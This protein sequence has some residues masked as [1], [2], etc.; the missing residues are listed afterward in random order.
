MARRG[1]QVDGLDEL[2]AQLDTLARA[3]EPIARASLYEGARVVADALAAAARGLPN[4]A[5]LY[6]E[7]RDEIANA[8]GV[9]KFDGQ[10]A[11]VSTAIGF[12]GYLSRTEKNHPRGV[13]IPIVVRAINNGSSHPRRKK[14]AF[15]R[16]AV[17]S[18]EPA[19]LAAMQAKLDEMVDKIAKE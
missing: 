5:I 11:S 18:A 9:A 4:G 19:A 6:P 17:R 10:G 13:P 7:E 16:Q 8:V 3:A 1:I 12:N 15:I 14:K 2:A